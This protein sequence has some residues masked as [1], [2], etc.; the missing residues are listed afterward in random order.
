MLLS[1]RT[2][3]SARLPSLLRLPSELLLDILD[4]ALPMEQTRLT[5]PARNETLRS[6]A[7]VHPCLTSWAQTRLYRESAIYTD[8]AVDKLIELTATPKG[9]GGDLAKT[10][11]NLRIYGPLSSPNTLARLVQQ[12]PHLEN[13]QL[14][15]LD[16]LE[17]RAFLLLPSELNPFET[18]FDEFISLTI[19]RNVPLTTDLRTFEACRSG[20][21][22]RFRLVS[23]ARASPLTSFS[24]I[25]CTAHDDAFSG[26]TLPHLRSLTLRDIS[27]P[28]PSPLATLEHSEAFKTLA[29]ETIPRLSHLTTDEYNF[30]LHFPL[31]QRRFSSS[32]F[33]TSSLN[34]LH[35][36]KLTHL[37]P[38]I[39]QLPTGPSLLPLSTLQ[40]TPTSSFLPGS[41][42]LEKSDAHFDSLLVPFLPILHPALKNLSQLILDEKYLIWLELGEQRIEKLLQA[43]EK[44]GIEVRFVESPPEM[45]RGGRR[46]A[47][48]GVISAARERRAQSV[49]GNL[50]IMVGGANVRRYTSAL[51]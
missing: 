45:E 7:L 39:D 48:T 40:L 18:V 23:Q 29:Y 15:D 32:R 43:C 3:D 1:I 22:S 6:L 51:I 47:G 26:F 46:R 11:V 21:R 5:I 25:N 2:S 41:T 35:L 19:E 36:I 27:L 30:L 28:P 16:G 49:S 12:L 8:R 42:S 34:S 33:P 14:N 13:L 9:R 24:I 17:M 38:L 31:R 20:F 37:S 4:L 44:R 50:S 10:I